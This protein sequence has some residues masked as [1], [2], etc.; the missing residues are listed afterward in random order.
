[1]PKIESIKKT[2]QFRNVYNRGVSFANKSLVL[3]V[4]KKKD[5]QSRLGVSVSKK[6]GKS[7]IRNR[8][9]RLI[10]ENI[11]LM[12]NQIKPGFDLVFIV[13]LPAV[14]ADFHQIRVSVASLLSKHGVIENV[15]ASQ[16]EE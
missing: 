7:V 8:I 3:F 1:M 12:A 9:K 10:K 16:S 6:I 4:Y 14:N 5:R 15:K 11:R 13:R 2:R